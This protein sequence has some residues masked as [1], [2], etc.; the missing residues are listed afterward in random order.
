MPLSQACVDGGAE[1]D[2]SGLGRARELGNGQ[3]SFIATIATNM[4]LS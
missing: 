4:V 2:D 1:A 3:W